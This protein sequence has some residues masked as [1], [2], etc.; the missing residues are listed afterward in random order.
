MLQ[1][2]KNLINIIKM[3]EKAFQVESSSENISIMSFTDFNSERCGVRH[4]QHLYPH[5]SVSQFGYNF[6]IRI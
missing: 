5:S 2:K 6:T 4:T 3:H 1:L